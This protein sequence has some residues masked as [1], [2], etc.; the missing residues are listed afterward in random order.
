MV[1]LNIHLL[2]MARENTC[3]PAMALAKK[4]MAQTEDDEGNAIEASDGRATEMIMANFLADINF[5]NELPLAER[6]QHLSA[7]IR[8]LQGLLAAMPDD[9][10]DP[11]A[12]ENNMNEAAC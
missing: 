11:Q 5:N 9:A 8:T 3:K 12:D 7:Y 4:H 10:I 1:W 6:R 2:K